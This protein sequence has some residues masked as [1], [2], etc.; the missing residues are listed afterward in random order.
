MNASKRL[1]LKPD[2]MIKPG[3]WKTLHD[4]GTEA[5]LKELKEIAAKSKKAA[6]EKRRKRLDYLFEIDYNQGR[7]DKMWPY[8]LAKMMTSCEETLQMCRENDH[9][10]DY[11]RENP[12]H[13][14]DPENYRVNNQYYPNYEHFNDFVDDYGNDDIYDD[15]Y[16]EETVNN[17]IAPVYQSN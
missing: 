12:K 17:S 4:H 3:P 16:G 8:D 5:Y 1:Q 11:I 6:E 13:E 14:Y 9:N 7:D 10:F 2:W 15:F